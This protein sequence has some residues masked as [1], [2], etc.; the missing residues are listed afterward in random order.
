VGKVGT[1]LHTSSFDP[2]SAR[3]L[4]AM[5]TPHGSVIK[6]H[7]T[8]WVENPEMYPATGMGGANVGPEFTAAE[9]LV[10]AELSAR[11][12]DLLRTQPGRAPARLLEALEDAVYG[13]GRW[14]KWLQPGEETVAFADLPADR[15][16]WL[17]QTGCRYIW[18][19]AAVQEER[20][21]LYDSLRVVLPDP[22]A[23][24]VERIA[25]SMERYITHFRLFGCM[26][27]FE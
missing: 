11:E 8:D 19:D 14:R 6:G 5:V 1:D 3:R 22:N 15:R 4:Y 23:F 10:L 9:Y 26:R 12:R 16:S 2:E 17:V 20:A 7:Y 24:V 27:L 13:S 21:R 25:L 18:T